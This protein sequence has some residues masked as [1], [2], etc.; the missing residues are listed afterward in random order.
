MESL[1]NNLP[2]IIK[3]SG[4]LFGIFA[5]TAIVIAIIGFSYFRNANTKQRERIFLYIIAFYLTLTLSALMGG[6][7]LGFRTGSK[8][9]VKR[10]ETNPSS[11]DPSLVRLSPDTI[12]S[13]DN[14]LSYKGEKITQENKSKILDEAVKAMA[15]SD[16]SSSNKPLSQSEPEPEKNNINIFK[17]QYMEAKI[18]GSSVST[19]DRP[20]V[21]LKIKNITS[22][23][24]LLAVKGQPE[25]ILNN[26][27]SGRCINIAGIKTVSS[28]SNQTSEP[29]HYSKLEPRAEIIVGL[30]DCLIRL[31][32]K[33]KKVSINIP[34]EILIND[35]RDGFSIG[36][37]EMPLKLFSE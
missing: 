22:K 27:E 16:A 24:F 1:F 8:D 13:L 12:Q 35:Q 5:L 2:E 21:S 9:V 4:S 34:F 36:I 30:S 6:N 7:V 25:V 14:V 15:N 29:L 10:I 20:Q 19:S 26:G 33:V 11:I 31:S 28:I 32:S 3:A 37:N 23:D 18:I 17:N